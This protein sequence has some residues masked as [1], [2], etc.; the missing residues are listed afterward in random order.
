M[1][2][3]QY[4]KRKWIA[5]KPF[6][7]VWL[8]TLENRVPVWHR[9]PSRYRDVLKRH[10]PVILSEKNFEG[11][12]G[13]ELTEEMK[14]IIAAYA[15]VPIL[16]ETG[17]YYGGLQAILVYPDNYIAPVREYEEGGV[18]TEGF[19][20][21][22]GEYWGTGNIVL[23]WSEIEKTLR[24][25][26]A[27]QNLIIHEFSHQLDDRYGLSAGI[28]VEGEAFRDDEWTQTLARSYRKHLRN[29][30]GR[31]RSVLDEYGATSPAE[32]FSVASEA[33]FESPGALH[34]EVPGLYRILREFYALDPISWK[35]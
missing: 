14:V 17:N 22:S 18:V 13:L 28:S 25:R 20:P 4:L 6:P 2:L 19:E 34:R 35:G 21:R 23:A 26:E 7:D 32:F 12:A 15:C 9:L 24:G 16:E 1:P 33:F 11:C 30:Q 31:R 27:G 8:K 5:R 10:I 29:M 3:I